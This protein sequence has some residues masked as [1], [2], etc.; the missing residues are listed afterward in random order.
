MKVLSDLLRDDLE[1]G[2]AERVYF[3]SSLLDADA[4]IVLCAPHSGAQAQGRG[5]FEQFNTDQVFAQL[6]H[7]ESPQKSP[8]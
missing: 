7:V 3:R 8:Q 2:L 5:N 4:N 1:C 6:G